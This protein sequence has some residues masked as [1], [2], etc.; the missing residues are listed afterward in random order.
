MTDET[1]TTTVESRPAAPDTVPPPSHAEVEAQGGV[2]RYLR[3]QV[4]LTQEELA[5]A[6]GITVGTVSRWE[7]GRFR[8]SRLARTLILDFARSHNVALDL[9]SASRSN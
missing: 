6:L 3:R 7:K 9:K 4:G 1:R 2:I 5:H 8:P